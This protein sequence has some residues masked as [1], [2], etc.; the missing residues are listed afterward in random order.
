MCSTPSSSCSRCSSSSTESTERWRT[1]RPLN[2][3][4]LQKVQWARQPRLGERGREARAGGLKYV[5]EPMMP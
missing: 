4:T 3:R 1:P 5:E 2:V